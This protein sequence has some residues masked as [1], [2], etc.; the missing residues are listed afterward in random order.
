[1]GSYFVYRPINPEYFEKVQVRAGASDGRRT[2]ILAGLEEG[3]R[4]VSRGAV[5]V[6]L[7]Q[8]A[9]GLD[10]HSGHAH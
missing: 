4:V 5:I 1:M 3:Q 10:A 9:G 7:A 8:A 6:K 2:E